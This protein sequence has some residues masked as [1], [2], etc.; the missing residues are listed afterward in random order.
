MGLL[1]GHSEQKIRGSTD[2]P[3]K[4]GGPYMKEEPSDA[5]TCGRPAITPISTA[6]KINR[7]RKVPSVG[8]KGDEGDVSVKIIGGRKALKNSWP[9]MAAITDSTDYQYCGGTLISDQWVLT[10]AHCVARKRAKKVFVRLGDHNLKKVES[11]NYAIKVQAK[12]IYIHRKYNKRSLS[13][14]V[15]LIKLKNRV[16]FTDQ[17]SPVCLPTV[18]EE[19]ADGHYCETTG[20]GWTGGFYSKKLRQVNVPYI[21]T[22]SCKKTNYGKEIESSMVCAGPLE[23][24]KDACYGDSGGPLVCKIES[25]DTVTWVQ[26]GITSWGYGCAQPN[27]PGVYSKVSYLI[28]W[29]QS[30][31]DKY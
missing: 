2:P 26:H 24:G 31:M 6:G 19:L 1:R 4:Y 17:I 22:S 27:S 14:D 5:S 8:D 16:T 7:R 18:N 30:T 11:P 13:N 28:P 20:W 9:W 25:G 15:A 21:T 29:I 23:G 10:A 12:E 3:I